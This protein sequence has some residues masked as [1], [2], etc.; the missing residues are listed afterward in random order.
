[1]CAGQQVRADVRR[2]GR[3]LT[4]RDTFEFLTP[5]ILCLQKLSE[6]LYRTQSTLG[7]KSMHRMP[8]LAG[9]SMF[10]ES[11]WNP[12]PG[13]CFKRTLLPS[14]VA[15]ALWGPLLR[16]TDALVHDGTC[17]GSEC[18]DCWDWGWWAD[19]VL[20]WYKHASSQLKL[21]SV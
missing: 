21:C 4:G 14:A 3:A 9:C 16:S 10:R 2:D 8:L 6:A 7:A 5:R 11:P 20:D 15:E 19:G 1:M 18:H 12:P 13:H 17:K